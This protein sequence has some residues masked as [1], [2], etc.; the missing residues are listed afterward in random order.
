MFKDL[1]DKAFAIKLFR[2][3]LLKGKEYRERI[4]KH[5][6]NGKPNVSPI[7]T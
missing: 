1:E 2:Q 4:D 3:S 6:K 5:M 7:W